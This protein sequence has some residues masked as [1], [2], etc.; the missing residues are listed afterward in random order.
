MRQ[1]KRDVISSVFI[2]RPRLAVVLAVLMTLAGLLAMQRMPLSQFPDIVPPQVVVSTTY[3]GASA[4]VVE[5][6]VAQPL[7]AAV[8]GV[9]KMIYMKSNSVNDGSYSLTVSFE[10]G[11]NP[12]VNTVNVNNRVQQALARLPA[13]VQKNGL[14]VRK[15]SSA[16]LEF[17]Q[18][19]SEGGQRDP[20]FIS[21]YVTIN[22]LDRLAR[23][24]GVGDA[25]L[26]GRLDYS[27]RIW[28]DV[29]RLT[30][31]NLSPADIISVIQTQNVQ[32]AVGR[33]GARPTSDATQFQLNVQTQG[34]LVTPSQFGE[35][36]I[37]ANPDGSLLRIRDVA[38]TELGAANS[39]TMSRLN[40]NP[41]VS[42]GIYLS[43]GA[44]AVQT[45]AR[46]QAALN[47]LSTRFPPSIKAR[48][49][50][51]SSGFVAATIDEVEKTLGIAFV[52][53]VAVVFVFLGS[54]RATIIPMLAIPVSLIGTFALMLA[55]GISANT[56]SLL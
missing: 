25:T 18:F 27:M 5:Q 56:I 14:I 11:T 26:F 48:V 39:D 31:L 20:L 16:I 19:Y 29:D 42:I 15:K 22:V 1:E 50:Y 32:A 7:E 47:D 53:V 6:T 30:Q 13:E 8:V 49:F 54:V 24:P 51:D 34:R 37:R 4:S 46:V 55:M 21:N 10:L 12:D 44:N 2:D 38:R 33:I 45:S 41:A 9:D 36:V 3:P 23:T 28:F 17:L 52:L 43:P 40:G 35:I